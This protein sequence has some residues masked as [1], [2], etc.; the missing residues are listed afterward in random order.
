MKSQARAIN[1]LTVII[2]STR[3]LRAVVDFENLL[4]SL[5]VVRPNRAEELF[6]IFLQ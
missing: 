2:F 1:K 4:D 3:Q 6:A 5:E